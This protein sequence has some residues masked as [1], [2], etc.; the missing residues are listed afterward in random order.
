MNS[1]YTESDK[2]VPA[3]SIEPL[4][5]GVIHFQDIVDGKGVLIINPYKDM[6]SGQTIKWRVY[7]DGVLL[8]FI[9]VTEVKQYI[10]KMYPQ[11][12]HCPEVTALY[13]VELDGEPLF[14]SAKVH[15]KVLGYPSE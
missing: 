12:F 3:P 10:V 13:V 6:A 11:V 1:I 2:M 7:G 4:H 15:Y 14:H 5:N 8:G 9:E